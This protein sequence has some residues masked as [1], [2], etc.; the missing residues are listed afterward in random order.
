MSGTASASGLK[1]ARNRL[2]SGSR[3]ARDPR[4]ALSEFGLAR[5]LMRQRQQIDHGTA[6]DAGGSWRSSPRRRGH[7]LAGEEL[8]AVDQA[9]Q[10]HRLAPERMD[11]MPV[12]D[13]MTVLAIGMSAAARQRHLMGAAEID[14]EPVVI[15]ARPQPVT[16]QARRHAIEYLA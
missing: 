11:H 14:L 3:P 5:P 15:E 7:R 4:E 1:S 9:H 2:R 6:G 12:V 8:V 10:R 13:D 16:D